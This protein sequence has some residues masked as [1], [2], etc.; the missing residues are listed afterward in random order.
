VYFSAEK[1]T[2]ISQ[3]DSNCW[4]VCQTIQSN[5]GNSTGKVSFSCQYQ[6]RY[7]GSRNPYH[8]EKCFSCR[9]R[10]IDQ[11]IATVS[12]DFTEQINKRNNSSLDG[13]KINRIFIDDVFNVLQS[14]DSSSGNPTSVLGNDQSAISNDYFDKAVQKATLMAIRNWKPPQSKSVAP[15]ES[16]KETIAERKKRSK[17]HQCKKRG[18]WK[19]DK[20][21]PKKKQKTAQV[22]KVNPSNSTPAPK[23]IPKGMLFQ[24]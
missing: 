9:T 7:R 6:C 3:I 21:C 22:S 23:E 19:G 11:L 1:C 20:E 14:L 2:I 4:G 16:G 15:T 24:E 5:F 10:S 18:H 12:N 17:C 13:G 8:Y